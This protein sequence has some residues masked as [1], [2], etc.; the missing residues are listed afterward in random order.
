MFHTTL[1]AKVKGI[2]KSI[3]FRPSQTIW[4][5]SPIFIDTAHFAARVILKEESSITINFVQNMSRL[6]LIKDYQPS[7]VSLMF[8]NL[9]SGKMTFLGSELS[10]KR[11]ITSLNFDK[12]IGPGEYIVV[13]E[14]D[15]HAPLQSHVA[16]STH[17]ETE[18]INILNECAN[19][20]YWKECLLQASAMKNGLQEL[21]VPEF[22]WGHSLTPGYFYWRNELRPQSLL[23]NLLSL[24]TTDGQK[25]LMVHNLE[26]K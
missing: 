11:E 8:G 12:T 13:A 18:K 20:E 15:F 23:K 7:R 5:A 1:I 24:V 3:G 25:P 6:D 16:I 22:K 21:K 17:S 2:Y 26:F 19:A 9:V 14:V 4:R 10:N